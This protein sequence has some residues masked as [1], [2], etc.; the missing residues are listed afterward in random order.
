VYIPMRSQDWDA[1]FKK[2]QAL[3]ETAIFN[4]D[5]W[6]PQKPGVEER[7]V[8][9][10]AVQ[11]PLYASQPFVSSQLSQSENQVEK[12]SIG[13]KHL[14]LAFSKRLRLQKVAHSFSV[15]HECIIC[16]RFH[17]RSFDFMGTFHYQRLNK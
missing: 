12:F 2:W 10:S 13:K 5:S 14:A 4:S 16:I 8:H 6:T 7:W 9:N 1:I 3:K 15:V 17:K 11:T